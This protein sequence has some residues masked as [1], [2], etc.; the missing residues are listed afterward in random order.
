MGLLSLVPSFAWRWLALALLVAAAWGHGYVKGLHRGEAEL[1]AYQ[2]QV[3][4]VAD[5]QAIHTANAVLQQ[6]QV[7]NSVEKSYGASIQSIRDYYRLHPVTVVRGNPAKAASSGGV[8]AIPESPG[9][10]NG[11]TADTGATPP[12]ALTEQ[13]AETTQQLVSLQL[14]ILH[15]EGIK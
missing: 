5:Q 1:T 11:K 12:D 3:Q 7:T 15:Q 4:H 8:P 13:C 10:P 14:W 6:T 9:Q 2:L